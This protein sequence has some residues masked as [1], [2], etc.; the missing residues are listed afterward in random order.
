MRTIYP[1]VAELIFDVGHLLAFGAQG[2]VTVL[3]FQVLAALGV[4][5]IT[6]FLLRAGLRA[7][8]PLWP[9]AV[10][11]WS[12]LVVL[13]YGNNAHVDWAAVVLS[14][15]CLELARRHRPGWTGLLL[16]AATLTKI[17]PALIGA[18][19]LKRRPWLVIVVATGA[20]V[21]S[22]V[23]HV[24]AV[25]TD[26][27]GYLPGYLHEEGY[28]SGSRL[29]LLGVILPHPFDTIVGLLIIA[30]AALWCWRRSNADA[31]EQTAVVLVGVAFLEW[32]PVAFAPAFVYLV[33]AEVSKSSSY[34]T[35]IYAVAGGLTLLAV[36][37]RRRMRTELLAQIGVG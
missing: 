34:G 7:R 20:V 8:R 16:A 17:Y 3:V 9:V 23:P 31:P 12:P 6:V 27:I 2:R 32:V 35:T 10:W 1:P 29:L 13:E 15:G 26:V 5:A 22:Y 18:T 28:S 30:A 25:G 37:A 33:R 36:L 21:V 24:L 4:L 14:L 19:V 11:A